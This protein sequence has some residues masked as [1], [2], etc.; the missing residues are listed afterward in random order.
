M[1]ELKVVGQNKRRYDGLGHVTGEATYVDDV[2]VPGTLTVKVLRSPL[3]KGII[4]KLDVSKA[5]QLPGVHG[6][7]T[8]EDVPCNT[9]G[10]LT[11]DQRCWPIRTCATRASPSP[12][13]RPTR[14]RSPTRPGA[15]R[16]GDRKADAGL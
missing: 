2:F 6:V 13:W 7:I 14:W 11:L 8:W 5:E 1:S 4:K 16:D 9:Y 3:H 12:R 10:Y 15:H